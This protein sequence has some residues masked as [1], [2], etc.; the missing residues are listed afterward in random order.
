MSQLAWNFLKTSDD[1]LETPSIGSGDN[2]CKGN[3]MSILTPKSYWSRKQVK[4]LTSRQ[5]SPSETRR[6]PN[7]E[8]LVLEI[9]QSSPSSNY[10]L[11]IPNCLQK[12]KRRAITPTLE[13]KY[14][15]DL[16]GPRRAK[17]TVHKYY[18]GTV[19]QRVPVGMKL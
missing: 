17:E 5:P 16:G 8:P 18:K 12:C 7:V 11:A 4:A 2:G 10:N 15:S 6:A 9:A 14:V 19:Q 13:V 1:T 3:E